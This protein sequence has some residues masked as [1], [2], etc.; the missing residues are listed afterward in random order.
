MDKN[1]SMQQPPDTGKLTNYHY[2]SE[3]DD[4]TPGMKQKVKNRQSSK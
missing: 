1:Q 2:G 4:R 3:K